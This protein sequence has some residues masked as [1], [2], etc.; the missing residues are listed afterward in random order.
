MVRFALTFVVSP[1]S[2]K[3]KYNFKKTSPKPGIYTETSFYCC[4]GLIATVFPGF[5]HSGTVLTIFMCEKTL[6]VVK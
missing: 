5:D 6:V 2:K 4:L 3:K 1:F